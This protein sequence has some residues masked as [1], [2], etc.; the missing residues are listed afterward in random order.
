MS[1]TDT[2]RVLTDAIEPA[3][4]LL[5]SA[6]DSLAARVM[7]I[8]IGLQESGLTTLQQIGGPAHGLW[9]AEKGG[10]VRGV[11]KNPRTML[12]AARLCQARHVPATE[13]DVYEAL[14]TDDVLAAGIARLGLWAD[15]APLPAIGDVHGAWNCYLRNW[16]PGKPRPADWG[17]N[18]AAAVAAI[19]EA[20]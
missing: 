1:A 5:P 19:T 6:M 13:A 8:A 20:P 4:A 17:D 14:L 16:R 15:L 18:Y 12:S 7:L 9:Q 3:L 11:L 10:M 2:Q